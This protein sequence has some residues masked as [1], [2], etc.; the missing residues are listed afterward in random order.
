[1]ANCFLDEPVANDIIHA[2]L[3]AKEGG[4]E[5]LARYELF[6]ICTEKD[7]YEKGFDSDK[8]F[9]YSEQRLCPPFSWMLNMC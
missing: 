8:M 7:K 3:A 5:R 1:M 2:K 4:K 6:Q 9:K